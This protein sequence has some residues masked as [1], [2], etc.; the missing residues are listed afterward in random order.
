MLSLYIERSL[1]VSFDACIV[2]PMQK[3]EIIEAKIWYALETRYEELKYI[4]LDPL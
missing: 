4:Q 1:K 2:K 3:G